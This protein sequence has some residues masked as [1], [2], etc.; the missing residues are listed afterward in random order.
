MAVLGAV[1]SV[2]AFPP[3]GPGLLIVPGIALLLLGLRR[4]STR[5]Q[6]FW[7]GGLYG[8][9][10]FGWLMWWLAELELIAL[11]LVPEQALFV[12]AYGWWLVRFNESKPAQWLTLAV[13][14]W[15][16]MELIRYHFPVGGLEWGAGGYALSDSVITRLPASVVGTSGL[17]IVVVL[18]AALLALAVTGGAGRVV[19][20]GAIGT[21]AV[22]AGAYAWTYGQER[23]EVATRVSIVQGSTPCPF[24]HCPPNERL[25]TFEQHLALTE[26]LVPGAAGLVVWPEGSTGSTNADPVL[27]DEVRLAIG[28]QA[29]RLSSPM[30]IGGDRVISET[31]WVNANVYFDANGEIVAEYRKQHGVPFGEYIPLR[32]IFEWIPALDRVP[33]DMIRGDGPVLFGDVGSVISFEGAFSRYAL[34]NRRAGAKVI[35]VNTNEASYGVDAPTSDQFIGMTRMRAVELGVPIIHAAVTGQ[36]TVIDVDGDLSALTG[37][38]TMEVLSESYGAALPTTPYAVIGDLVMYLAAISCLIVWS[39]ALVGSG[40]ETTEED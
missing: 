33:R 27:N 10:F 21:V 11:V 14:G 15:A 19:L 25:G 39:F 23:D 34:E 31:H 32:P 28:D 17:T 2:L 38:G 40:S 30:V 20:W 1:L 8:L 9:V 36:S 29:R 4:C 3:Y 7:T 12:A 26:G 5:S 35:V 24:E 18:I 37:L 22:L 6:G 13:G 16:F